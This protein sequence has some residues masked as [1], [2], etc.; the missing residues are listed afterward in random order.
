M[1]SDTKLSDAKPSDTPSSEGACRVVRP[2]STIV[3]K[4]AL[5]YA[6]A[7]DRKS[8]RLNSSHCIQSRWPGYGWI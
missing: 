1:S 2:G 7:V 4:Q 3:G 6:P 5:T 8:T